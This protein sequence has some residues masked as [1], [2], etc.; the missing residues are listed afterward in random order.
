MD[1]CLTIG[2]NVGQQ[3]HFLLIC[4]LTV[5]RGKDWKKCDNIKVNLRISKRCNKTELIQRSDENENL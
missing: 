4:N 3:V 2:K 5:G 1:A